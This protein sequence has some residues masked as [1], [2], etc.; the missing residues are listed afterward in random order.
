MHIVVVGAGPVGSAFVGYAVEDGN[1]VALIEPDERPEI[2]PVL[3]VIVAPLST[4][5]AS[6]SRLRRR[7]SR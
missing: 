2:V 1:D 7:F 5:G 4:P 3:V 6:L